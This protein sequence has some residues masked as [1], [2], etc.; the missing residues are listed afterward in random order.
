[1]IS[2][3]EMLCR[4]TNMQL[5]IGEVEAKMKTLST[6][7]RESRQIN[8]WKRY[9]V[10]EKQISALEKAL[11]QSS[12]MTKRSKIVRRRDVRLEVST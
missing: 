3:E 8:E 10:I 4:L 2:K 12:F 1:M 6:G 11:L 9:Y 7:R 5:Q